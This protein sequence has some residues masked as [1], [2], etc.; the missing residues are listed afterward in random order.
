MFKEKLKADA[1]SSQGV[2]EQLSSYLNSLFKNILY[3]Y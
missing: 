3:N 2:T 1:L